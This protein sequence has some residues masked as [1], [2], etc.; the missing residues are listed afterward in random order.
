MQLL[1]ARPQQLGL[2][3]SKELRHMSLNI[4]SSPGCPRAVR[5]PCGRS[6]HGS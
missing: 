2:C 6:I 5:V 3:V 1:E 4:N